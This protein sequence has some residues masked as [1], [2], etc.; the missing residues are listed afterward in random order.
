[1]TWVAHR[2][3][4]DHG[5]KLWN[6]WCGTDAQRP[7]TDPCTPVRMLNI[8]VR[9]LAPRYGSLDTAARSPP[10]DGPGAGAPCARP[11]STAPGGWGACAATGCPPKRR[12]PWTMHGVVAAA[13]AMHTRT[14]DDNVINAKYASEMDFVH[15]SAGGAP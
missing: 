11:V 13:Q 3:R 14:F 8:P 12:P 1:M 5:R 15:A 9:T 10:A 4:G 6:E 7:G 2:V